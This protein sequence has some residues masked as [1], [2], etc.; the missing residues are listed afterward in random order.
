MVCGIATATHVSG[1]R[2]PRTVVPS[3]VEI[4]ARHQ[5][6][7]YRQG[8]LDGLCGLYGVI[9]ALR[10]AVADNAPLSKVQSKAL[11]AAGVEFLH[12]KDELHHAAVTGLKTSR[13]LAL[14]RH[15]AKLVSAN[16]CPVV[17]ER[18][19]YAAW[20][21]TDDVFRW[22]EQ[23]LSDGKPVMAALM[24]GLNH[25]TVISGSDA[26]KLYFFDSDGLHFVH[27]RNCGLNT[28]YHRIPPKGLMR[29]AVKRAT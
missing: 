24:G 4:I 21:S 16:H 6:E 5:L 1:D 23:S 14:A 27:K 8:G 29:I 9:N 2:T 20:A 17:V 10:L 25:F 12:R 13:R 11:F 22:I 19:D 18:P 15:L 28:G 26:A 3:K 7:P